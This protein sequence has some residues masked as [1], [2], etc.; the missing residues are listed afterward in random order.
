MITSVTRHD[1]GYLISAGLL[2]LAAFVALT[3]LASDLWDLND[4]VYHKYAGYVLALMAL[5]HVYLHW[6]RLASY[7]RWRLS[8]HPRRRRASAVMAG[9]K[10]DQRRNVH[11]TRKGDRDRVS[12]AAGHQVLSRRTA[13]TLA[14]GGVGGLALGRLLRS[15][16]ELPFGEDVGAI[17]HEWSK[18]K[19]LSLLGTVAD[20][21]QSPPLYKVHAGPY[22]SQAAADRDASRVYQ[23]LGISPFVVNR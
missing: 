1:L 12:A 4:F 17:Y 22:E 15:E 9:Q 2:I 13:I 10:A 8:G 7:I 18:P 5:A 19:L 21:G 16:P 23:V 14:L 6:G 3:G 20:W 11:G